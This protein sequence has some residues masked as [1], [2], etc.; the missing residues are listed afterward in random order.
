MQVDFESIFQLA[1]LVGELGEEVIV[2][3][4]LVNEY[5]FGR[6]ISSTFDA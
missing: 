2:G 3:N 5:T 1:V 6:I 4:V